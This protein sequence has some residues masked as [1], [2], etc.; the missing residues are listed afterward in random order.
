MR[1]ICTSIVATLVLAGTTLAAIITVPDDYASI[2]AAIDADA[3]STGLLGPIVMPIDSVPTTSCIGPE[4]RARIQGIVDLYRAEHPE[5]GAGQPG[6]LTFFP[7][8]GRLYHD[9]YT[10]NYV[11]LD[12][13]TG[14]LDWDCSNHTY[15]GHTGNDTVLRSFD[16]QAVGVPVYAAID[17]IVVWSADGYFDMNT[18]VVE[19]CQNEAN[20][21]IID[22][23]GDLFGYYWHHRNGSVEVVA[24]DTVV[25]GEQIALIGSS[26]CSTAPHLHFELRDEAAWGGSVIEPSTGDCNPGYSL[27]Q[28][29][30]EIVREAYIG[31]VG[32]TEI[33]WD[34]WPAWPNRLPNQAQ[35]PLGSNVIYGWQYFHNFN[36]GDEW[37]YQFRRPDGVLACEYSGTFGYTIRSLRLVW[38]IPCPEMSSVPGAWHAEL[39]INGESLVDTEILIVEKVDPD[40]NR[41]PW[42]ISI[43]LYPEVP[44]ENDVIE[45]VIGNDMLHDDP[46]R[47]VVQYRYQWSVNGNSVRDVISAGKTDVLPTDAAAGGDHVSV[48]VFASDG[49]LE[50]PPTS[51]YVDVFCSNCPLGACCTDNQAICTLANESDCDR[52]GGYWLGAGTT[53]DGSPC[54]TACL[55][56]INGDGQVSVNDLLT[57]IANWGP[58]P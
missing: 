20:A 55:G 42:P 50:S 15:D 30:E 9:V 58:C 52:F 25:A 47:N 19:N 27:W 45:C 44:D 8:G 24:G 6:Q 1:Y 5:R 18:E 38:G 35:I 17:G 56:D 11:D 40:F 26:G 31:D 36:S 10:N 39:F 54:P 41:A 3:H 12:P 29:Q 57:V 49:E 22:H 37:T 4:T 34:Q 16:E 7:M 21:I 33:P 43:D 14:L 23:G 13:T 51:G 46:D 2:Q 28:D 32:V 53:C 48:I